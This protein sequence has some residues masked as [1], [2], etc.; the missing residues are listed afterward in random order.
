M[1]AV[2]LGLLVLIAHLVHTRLLT[3]VVVETLPDMVEAEAVMDLLEQAVAVL[4]AELV[5]VH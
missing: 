1:L 3:A 5:V 4:L 2:Q